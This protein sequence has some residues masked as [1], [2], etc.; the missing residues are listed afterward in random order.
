VRMASASDEIARSYHEYRDGKESGDDALVASSLAK[1]QDELTKGKAAFSPDDYIRLLLAVSDATLWLF[2]LPTRTEKPDWL[3]GVARFREAIDLMDSDE[4]L[5]A[6]LYNEMASSL[7]FAAD[8]QPDH[9]N[10]RLV[11]EEALSCY[12]SSQSIDEFNDVAVAGVG[13]VLLNLAKLH[14]ENYEQQAEEAGEALTPAIVGMKNHG[15]DLLRQASEQ[16]HKASELDPTDFRYLVWLGEVWICKAS[17]ADET[18]EESTAMQHALR[19]WRQALDLDPDN[20]EIKSLL[21]EYDEFFQD[22]ASGDDDADAEVDDDAEEEEDDD[23][24][25]DE[26]QSDEEPAISSNDQ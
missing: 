25:D 17:I 12:R 16:L 7:T 1:L 10:Y 18:E 26:Q 2:A 9:P 11:M 13:S 8:A 15:I 23:D 4:P 19:L 6:A 14:L 20:K 22:Q 5:R 24:D 3:F 21:L